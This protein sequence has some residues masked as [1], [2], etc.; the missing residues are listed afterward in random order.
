VPRRFLNITSIICLVAC[1]ALMGLSVRSYYAADDVRGRFGDE[2]GFAV[3]S[4]QGRLMLV[5]T[6]S[7]DWPWMHDSCSIDTSM[8]F[9]DKLMGSGFPGVRWDF[10]PTG[11][12]RALV[13]LWMP[14]L[15]IGT[16]A[17]AFQ[18]RRP[19]RFTLRSLFLVTTFLAAVLGMIARLP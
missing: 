12:F 16:L 8:R 13:P 3:V 2:R 17:G 18:I 6:R 4:M 7:C 15:T 1:V 5:V 14:V 9:P 11:C 10:L 19:W